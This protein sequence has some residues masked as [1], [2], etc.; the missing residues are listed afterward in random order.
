MKCQH[1]NR[2]LYDFC[3]NSLSPDIQNQ[4]NNHLHECESCRLKVQLTQLENEV[5]SDKSTIPPL[6][7]NFT[8][9]V[10][11]NLNLRMASSAVTNRNKVPSLFK[12]GNLA[13][14]A[15]LMA[16]VLLMIVI[17]PQVI[18]NEN[19][20]QIA[21]QSENNIDGQALVENRA[22]TFKTMKNDKVDPE[23]STTK[24]YHDSKEPLIKPTGKISN[25]KQQVA[26]V[27]ND[28]VPIND[29]Q[30]TN[31]QSESALPSRNSVSSAPASASIGPANAEF[32]YPINIPASYNFTNADK[33]DN[34]T[35]QYSFSE[36]G[37][38]ELSVIV[39]NV[40][41]NSGDLNNAKIAMNSDTL[42]RNEFNT[43]TELNPD[44]IIFEINGVRYAASLSGNISSEEA[45]ELMKVINFALDASVTAP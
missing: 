25:E 43:S 26:M 28:S 20:L 39:T 34:R 40:Q 36:S 44:E 21:D 19:Q 5:L 38:R 7:D 32:P 31:N 24:E 4:I 30:F 15:A 10:M 35:V 41:S 37:Q 33:I 18:P 3:D 27:L 6:S 8:D 9:K 2:Y 23:I 29:N 12:T 11:E 14:T 22:K 16:I 17:A 45:N 13:W 1:V 42:L